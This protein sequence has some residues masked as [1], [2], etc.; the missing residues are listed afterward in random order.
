MYVLKNM[1]WLKKKIGTQRLPASGKNILFC[2]ST[3]I[4]RV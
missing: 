3:K 1:Y 2:N 4:N